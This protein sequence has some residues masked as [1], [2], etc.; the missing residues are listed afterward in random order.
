M[1]MECHNNQSSADKHWIVRRGEQADAIATEYADDQPTGRTVVGTL[2]RVREARPA[3]AATLS[4]SRQ[5]DPAIIESW[6][7]PPEGTLIQDQ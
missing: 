7:F 3:S 6:V 5:D 1:A 2:S 4:R